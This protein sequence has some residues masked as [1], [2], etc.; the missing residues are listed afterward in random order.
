M[1]N[2]HYNKF[3]AESELY[4]GTELEKTMGKAVF[5]D[6]QPDWIS[7]RRAAKRALF[8]NVSTERY[9]VTYRALYYTDELDR[10]LWRLYRGQQ[11]ELDAWI[12]GEE[13]GA[14]RCAMLMNSGMQRGVLIHRQDGWIRQACIPEPDKMEIQREQEIVQ[15][16]RI[17]AEDARGL[18][19]AAEEPI[20]PGIYDASVLLRQIAEQ[21]DF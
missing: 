19:V 6:P 11:S 5:L 4:G 10:E 14:K 8:E 18:S 3:N 15:R 7:L 21:F 17:L 12:T 9:I 20:K 13:S 2:S 16:L 1:R